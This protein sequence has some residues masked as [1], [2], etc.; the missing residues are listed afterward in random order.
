MAD[1]EPPVPP[2]IFAATSHEGLS[3]TTVDGTP[4]QLA[5]VDSRGTIL[6]AGKEVAAAV[7]EVSVKSYRS[8]LRGT[9]HLREL[10]EPA[11]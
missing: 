4:A 10:K 8:F 3:V 7:Y 2:V 11:R 9:G 5:V 6:A 1:N